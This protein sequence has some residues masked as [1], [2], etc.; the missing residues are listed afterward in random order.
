LDRVDVDP[1]YFDVK[2]WPTVL[3]EILKQEQ[4]EIY[5]RRKQAVEMYLK[6]HTHD[7]IKE[8]TALGRK[9]VSRYINRCYHT[10]ITE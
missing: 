2:N 9:E 10:T 5:N 4:K 6:N 1:K 8:M 7:E 3:I